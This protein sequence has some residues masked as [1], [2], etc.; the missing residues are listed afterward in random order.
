MWVL[1]LGE[2]CHCGRGGHVGRYL[3]PP[4]KYY[5]LT[6]VHH[7]CVQLH[8]ITRYQLTRWQ[9]RYLQQSTI[10]YNTTVVALQAQGCQQQVCSLRANHLP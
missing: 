10:Q 9:V 5:T 7:T 8:H 3:T 4:P 1:S 2:R 6:A